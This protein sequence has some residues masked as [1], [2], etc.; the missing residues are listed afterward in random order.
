MIK[1]ISVFK[2]KDI[3]QNLCLKFEIGSRG[4]VRNKKKKYVHG[5]KNRFPIDY[6]GW[7]HELFFCLLNLEFWM[8]QEAILFYTQDG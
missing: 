1:K 2:I 6:F 5:N 7:K 4:R 8:E 3:N